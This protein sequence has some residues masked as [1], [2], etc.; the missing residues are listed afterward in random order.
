VEVLPF[1]AWQEPH[2]D[3]CGDEHYQ[4][5][6]GYTLP[7]IAAAFQYIFHLNAYVFIVINEV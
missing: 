7:C 1:V 3:G 5:S 6:R 4:C 2:Y